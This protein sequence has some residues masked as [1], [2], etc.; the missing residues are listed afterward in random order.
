[1]ELFP[2]EHWGLLKKH[3]LLCA[4][5]KSHTFV[6]GMNNKNH[7][8]ECFEILE[9]AINDTSAAGFPNVMTF[10][11]LADTSGEK[12]GSIVTAE[13]GMRNCIE[14]YKK[15]AKIAEEKNVT[16][17]LEPLNSK[18][19]EN[20]KGHPGYTGDHIDYCMEIIQ[21]V[22]SP[23]FKLL[24]DVYHIQIM[25]GNLISNIFG[26]MPNSPYKSRT[27]T[28]LPWQ[29][30]KVDSRLTRN[31]TFMSW[32]TVIMEHICFKPAVVDGITCCPD[33]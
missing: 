1:M 5:T 28:G 30:K 13:E 19:N 14:G 31:S 23:A 26:V 24:F 6:R 15:M 22:S 25:D 11:G 12:N 7:H 10:T 32:L 29:A 2:V 18:V 9:K 21:A 4:A 20:M 33:N 3:K 16:L 8:A 27:A 17:I